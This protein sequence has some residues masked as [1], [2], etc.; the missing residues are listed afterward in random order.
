MNRIPLAFAALSLWAG[1]AFAATL[2]GSGTTVTE[3]REARNFTGISIGIPA[4]VEVVQGSAEGV[5]ISADDNVLP[6]IESVVERGVLKL[7]LR[8][9]VQLRKATIRVTVNAR[10]VESIGISGSADV[11]AAAL[12]TQRLGLSISGSGD[13]LL[14][15]KAEEVD[16]RISGAGDVKIGRLAAQ[17]A[18]VSISGSGD[19]TVWAREKLSVRVAGSGDVR[20]YGDPALEKRISGAGSVRRLGATPS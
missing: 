15:G 12:T 14:D 6:V 3:D 10:A 11:R 20:Y 1:S 17:R 9:G 2:S 16:V 19:A 8:E 18:S 5:R 4:R 7:R 13:M